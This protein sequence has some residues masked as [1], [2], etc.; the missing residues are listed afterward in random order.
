VGADD[1]FAGGKLFG[2]QPNQYDH[3]VGAFNSVFYSGP[4]PNN[5]ITFTVETS[6]PGDAYNFVDVGLGNISYDPVP[7]TIPLAVGLGTVVL[8]LVAVGRVRRTA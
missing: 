5:T 7:E 6:T 3:G 1:T 8:G 2:S 4:I